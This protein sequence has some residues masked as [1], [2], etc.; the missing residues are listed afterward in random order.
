[1]FKWIYCESILKKFYHKV[2]EMPLEFVKLAII[3]TERRLSAFENIVAAIPLGKYCF[4]SNNEWKFL[5]K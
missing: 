4:C 5:Q 1:M 3:I 2:E